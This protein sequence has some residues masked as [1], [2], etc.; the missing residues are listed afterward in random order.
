[1]TEL[2]VDKDKIFDLAWQAWNSTKQYVDS[3]PGKPNLT[4]A[5]EDKQ[6]DEMVRIPWRRAHQT[7]P[8]TP[9]LRQQLEDLASEAI[10]YTL[11]AIKFKAGGPYYQISRTREIVDG[12][13]TI[14]EKTTRIDQDYL[15]NM[16]KEIEQE[17]MNIT[18]VK[19]APPAPVAPPLM[20]TAGQTVVSIP[21]LK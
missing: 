7:R 18:G 5:Q 11:G 3:L 17:L 14:V 1:M 15:N 13:F 10:R 2:K 8:I 6:V 21:P 20:I 12:K 9:T 16:R 4:E 19:P